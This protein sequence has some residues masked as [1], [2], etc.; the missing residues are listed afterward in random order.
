MA[1]ILEPRLVIADEPTTALDV[2]IQAQI[3]ELLRAQRDRTGLALLLITHD[4]GVVAEMASRVLVMYAGQIVEEAPVATLFAAAAH[5][6]T[7]GLSPRSRD[8]S[9]ARSTP[10]I[11]GSA[12]PLA[13]RLPF[14]TAA[15][16]RSTG[17]S[18]RPGLCRWAPHRHAAT[19]CRS[20]APSAEIP[21]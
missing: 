17:A 21:A 10:T 4:L 8:R 7:E 14:A 19:W 12:P 20:R 16:T 3:L 13:D 11:R 15:R 18:P 9:V 6:Y 2:T 5:P 1:L